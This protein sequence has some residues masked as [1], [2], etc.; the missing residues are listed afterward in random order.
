MNYPEKM[1]GS[2]DQPH[3][4]S[5]SVL[6]ER[7]KQLELQ[8]KEALERN[9]LLEQLAQKDPLT[10][11]D[12]RRRFDEE[13][14]RQILGCIRR[15]QELSTILIDIDDFK[16][17]NDTYG[18]IPGDN[19]LTALAATIQRSIRQTDLVFRYGGE[20]FVI[21]LPDTPKS[22]AVEV[23]EKLRSIVADS[24]V[25]VGDQTIGVTISLGVDS[26]NPQALGLP[27]RIDRNSTVSFGSNLISGADRAM[28]RAKEGGKNTIG[29]IIRDKDIFTTEHLSEQAKRNVILIHK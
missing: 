11:L 3:P 19:V 8:L 6:E 26:F 29:V 28:Y 23:A 22:G 21:L 10:K 15:S 1:N 18:H 25:I 17:V 2:E 7:V 16:L 20:E 9:K 5:Q 14:Q 27:K 24:A 4:D 12:N 13:M